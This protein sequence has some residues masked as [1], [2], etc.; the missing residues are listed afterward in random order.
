MRWDQQHHIVACAWTSSVP[1]RRLGLWFVLENITQRHHISPHETRFERLTP[2][3]NC[4]DEE[5]AQRHGD[6]EP[7]AMSELHAS[8]LK[9]NL[10]IHRESKQLRTASGRAMCKMLLQYL[11]ADI[12]VQD[13]LRRII[14]VILV[15]PGPGLKSCV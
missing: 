5:D 6:G 15:M 10:P 13:Q 4:A 11:A 9:G 2:V 1:E 8:S 3:P 12:P 14:N 7:S